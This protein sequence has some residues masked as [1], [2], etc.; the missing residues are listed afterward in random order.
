MV[1]YGRSMENK[2]YYVNKIA[3]LLHVN[4]SVAYDIYTRMCIGGA[5]FSEMSQEQ[6]EREVSQT[7]VIRN[8]AEVARLNYLASF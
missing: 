6:F 1:T 3:D 7:F 2:M 5:D 4:T 8:N